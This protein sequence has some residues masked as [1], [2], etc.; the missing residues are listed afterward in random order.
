[1]VSLIGIAI[2]LSCDPSEPFRGDAWTS[3]GMLPGDFLALIGAAF[4]GVYTALLKARVG[5][6]S[7]VDMQML[8]GFSGLISALVL[9]PGVVI[10][11]MYGWEPFEL[12]SS[13]QVW[14]ML[15][16]TYAMNL[17]ANISWAYAMLLTTPLLVTV[18]LSL[19]TPVVLLG[20]MALLWRIPGALFWIGAALVVGAFVLIHLLECEPEAS[21]KEIVILN[22]QA[23]FLEFNDGGY[24]QV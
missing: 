7:H 12:P 9:W 11:H 23:V 15:A 6:E 13:L 20:Q 24:K 19:T 17:I 5:D 22:N 4:Y 16:A 14:V 3:T 21:E 18:G 8:F 10:V 1:M 2:I